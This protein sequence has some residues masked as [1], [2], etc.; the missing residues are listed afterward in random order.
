MRVAMWAPGM[1]WDGL[2]ATRNM[3]CSW[4]RKTQ[5][6]GV[7]LHVEKVIQDTMQTADSSKR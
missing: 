2:R 7:Q 4:Q 5:N 3:C 1:C 6:V